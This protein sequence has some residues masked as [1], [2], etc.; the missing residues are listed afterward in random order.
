MASLGSH[1]ALIRRGNVVHLARVATEPP[2]AGG[3]RIGL[4]FVGVCGT[5]LQI[6]NG[7]RPDTAEIL[8]HEGLGVVVETAGTGGLAVGDRVVF[9]PAA[10]LSRGWILGHNTPGLFQKFITVDSQA[11]ADGL[12]MLAN[13]CRPPVCG[14]LV[15]PLA[16]IVYAHELI[17]NAVPDLRT[18]VVLGGGPVGLLA[19]IYLS[20]LGVKILLVHPTQARLDTVARLKILNPTAM[21]VASEDVAERIKALNGGY[22][23]DAAL[24]CTTRAGAPSALHQA[25]KAVRHGGCVDLVTNYPENATAPHGILTPV[26]RAVRS[27]NVCGSPQEGRYLFA[28]IAGRRIAFTGH[29]GTG[30]THLK[31]ALHALS[32]ARVSYRRLITHV[33]PLREAADAIQELSESNSH[34][35]HGMDCIKLAVDMTIP[36]ILDRPDEVGRRV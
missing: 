8:G 13:G 31:K 3:L 19:A 5:D 27:A 33:L 25:V 32:G 23:V 14:A 21:L 30:H 4:S 28:D 22:W 35:I 15:E 10:Q 6:L 2:Q 11:V 24:I 17:S 34:V 16:A 20:G 29:R 12:V 1:E 7:S 9:N 18:L 26:L 36:S